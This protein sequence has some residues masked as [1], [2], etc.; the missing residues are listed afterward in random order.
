MW[1]S[2]KIERPAAQAIEVGPDDV[3]IIHTD[4]RLTK[5]QRDA[6]RTEW[7]EGMERGGVSIMD[8]RITITVLRGARKSMKQPA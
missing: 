3:V 6:I 7:S 5:E 2:K 4:G 8:D 1:E